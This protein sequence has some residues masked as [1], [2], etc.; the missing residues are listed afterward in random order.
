MRGLDRMAECETWGQRDP[1]NEQNH[2]DI[3]D[4]LEHPG[5][6]LAGEGNSFIASDEVGAHRLAGPAEQNHGG[7][8]DAGGRQDPQEAGVSCQRPKHNLPAQRPSNVSGQDENQRQPQPVPVHI[9]ER[10]GK[11]LPGKTGSAPAVE[12]ER[13][14]GRR[15]YDPERPSPVGAS[16]PLRASPC[17]F[18]MRFR[19]F[20]PRARTG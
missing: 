15:R 14:G 4:S 1:K 16:F 8:A 11:R 20:G 2:E 7:E 5:R 3:Q 9:A 17:A 18:V 19:P 6:N 13:H 12:D 10:I